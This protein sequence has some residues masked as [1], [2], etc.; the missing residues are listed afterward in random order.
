MKKFLELKICLF[1]TTGNIFGTSRL[2][3]DKEALPDVPKPKPERISMTSIAEVIP[4]DESQEALDNAKKNREERR[5]AMEKAKADRAALA[6]SLG[7]PQPPGAGDEQPPEGQKKDAKET[8]EGK[9]KAPKGKEKEPPK[10]TGSEFA[11]G[12]DKCK[13]LEEKQRFVLEHAKDFSKDSLK[14][15]ICERVLADGRRVKV[16]MINN[17]AIGTP[18]DSVRLGIDGMTSQAIAD[19]LG[20]VLPTAEFYQGNYNDPSIQKV[21]FFYGGT[22]ENEWRSRGLNPT[23]FHYTDGRGVTR[24]SGAAMQSGEYM[25]MHSQ[26][27]DEWMQK[28]GIDNN[29]FTV[30]SR[31]TVFAPTQPGAPDG[32]IVFGGGLY[33]I[34]IIDPDTKKVVGY[35]VDTSGKT[36][37]GIGDHAHEPGWHDYAAGTDIVV[38]IE[39]EGEKG[40]IPPKKFMTDEKYETARK[41]LFGV[42][43]N[44][45]NKY[46]YPPWM[47]SYIADYQKTE[48]A[49]ESASEPTPVFS[50]I[51]PEKVEK[52]KVT[53]DDD[54]NVAHGAKGGHVR[55][56]DTAEGNVALFDFMGRDFQVKF[57]PENTAGV[58]STEGYKASTGDVAGPFAYIMLRYFMQKGAKTGDFIPFEYDGKQYIAQYQIH[59]PDASAPMD[60][61]GVG[62]MQKTDTD[63]YSQIAAGGTWSSGNSPE[64][65]QPGPQPKPQSK[66]PQVG[67]LPAMPGGSGGFSGPAVSAPDISPPPKVGGGKGGGVHVGGM[68][69]G[70]GGMSSGGGGP[71][72]VPAPVRTPV[73]APQSIPSEVPQPLPQPA[74]VS[75]SPYEGQETNER[76]VIKGNTLFCGDSMTVEMPTSGGKRNLNVEGEIKT[77]AEGSKTV[78]WLLGQL[79]AYESSGE[80]QKM[81]NMVVLIGTNNIGGNQTA[82]TIFDKIEKIWEIGRRNHLK[83]YACTIPPVKGWGAWGDS[84]PLYERSNQKRK[85]INTLISTYN[86]PNK[87][88]KV[89]KLDELMADPADSD[90]LAGEYD[91]NGKGD[92]LHPNK[93]K[94]ARLLESGIGER[95]AKDEPAEPEATVGS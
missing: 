23:A 65:P 84:G 5:V 13:T 2:C 3:F 61:P 22:L 73:S 40:V 77:I 51:A 10:M 85:D 38:G 64:L 92:H 89:I 58:S 29:R 45:N 48:E 63:Q 30:G 71:S 16:H 28:N 67:N 88:D 14:P 83:V 59:G 43:S 52:G 25:A 49:H 8:K 12:F 32:Q 95:K 19:M 20:G 7:L 46:N 44:Y 15:R 26:M 4:D 76:P 78:E 50:G 80:I 31:K 70:S 68:G 75:S 81:K 56:V 47:Q 55:L 82:Q 93:Q 37:Q 41:E 60:H 87:P 53:L 72:D 18:E 6:A 24:P 62:I 54:Y 90:R 79:E 91:Y 94:H 69:S 35:K 74:K 66:P 21:P 9:D 57:D 33:S 39:I 86:G 1:S 27:L 11:A 34:P 42:N 17:L 36:V